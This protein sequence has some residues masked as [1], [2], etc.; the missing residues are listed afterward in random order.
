MLLAVLML[1][2]FAAGGWWLYHSPYL[3]VHE[4]EVEGTVRLSPQQIIDTAAID[5]VSTFA[6]DVEA[7][8]ARVAALPGVRSATI[9]KHG[10]SAATITVEERAA[11]GAWEINGTKVP[12]DIDGHVLDAQALPEGAPTIIEADPQGATNAGDRFDAGAIRLADRMLRESER[13]L[14]LYVEA[15][16]YRNDAGVTAVLYGPTLGNRRLWVTF[17]VSCFITTLS[18]SS[19]AASLLC[20]SRPPPMRW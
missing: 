18:F 8:E 3:T 10:W 20:T 17:E 15:L 16:I 6:V 13:T 1:G 19:L 14:G 5:G 11:W 4:I 2:L 9:E 7:A 12:I